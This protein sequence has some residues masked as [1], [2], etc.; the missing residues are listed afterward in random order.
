MTPASNCF[1]MLYFLHIYQLHCRS[2]FWTYYTTNIFLHYFVCSIYRE[3][4][5]R[6][7]NFSVW[8]IT[9]DRLQ[10]KNNRSWD[11]MAGME[12]LH[13]KKTAG[14]N[15]SAQS[16]SN[17]CTNCSNDRSRTNND[18]SMAEKCRMA[19]LRGIKSR[20]QFSDNPVTLVQQQKNWF[21]VDFSKSVDHCILIRIFS[22]CLLLEK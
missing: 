22:D 20:V 12:Y 9:L 17:Y 5:F 4:F 11:A 13:R 18:K 6:I 1:G 16:R 10:Q 8:D 7:Q 2:D 21:F 3:S 19:R 15:Q 14:G